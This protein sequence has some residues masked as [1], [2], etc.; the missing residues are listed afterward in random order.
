MKS[1]IK[2]AHMNKDKKDIIGTELDAWKN[3]E[4]NFSEFKQLNDEILSQINLIHQGG[5]P[6]A[7]QK[8][9]NKK[10]MTCRER[11]KY[12]IDSGESFFEIGTFAAFDMYQEYGNIASAA[13]VTGIG[14]INNQ[15]CMIIVL[16]YAL[17]SNNKKF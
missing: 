12:L 6:I 15:E 1:T 7:I 5:G 8:Q 2:L 3:T 11:V 17:G 13:V 10:R 16:G 9:H 14:K 4:S